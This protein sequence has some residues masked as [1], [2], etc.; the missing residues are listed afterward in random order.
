MKTKLQV[1]SNKIIIVTTDSGEAKKTK[2]EWLPRET[3]SLFRGKWVNYIEQV[4]EDKHGQQN[5]VI[6]KMN[7]K[8]ILIIAICR[9]PDRSGKRVHTIKA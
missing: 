4:H 8:S 1:R 7:E 6:M 3:L 5:A 2:G 9:L